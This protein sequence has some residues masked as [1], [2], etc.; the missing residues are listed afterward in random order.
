MRSSLSQLIEA[1]HDWRERSRSDAHAT[2]EALDSAS[3]TLPA[4]LADQVVEGTGG[5]ERV[6]LESELMGRREA[7][8]LAL[9]VV[10][11]SAAA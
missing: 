5:E 6:E 4:R 2:V 7:V 11:A 3:V 10:A 8:E 9:A 1:M